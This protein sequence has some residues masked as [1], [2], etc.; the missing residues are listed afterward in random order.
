MSMTMT[1]LELLKS[2]GDDTM[3]VDSPKRAAGAYCPPA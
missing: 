3:N 1:V 2:S